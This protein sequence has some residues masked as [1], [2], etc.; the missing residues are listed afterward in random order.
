M[1]KL[2]QII[3]QEVNKE[4]SANG[5]YIA[6][7]IRFNNNMIEYTNNEIDI[8]FQEL[9]KEGYLIQAEKE[10]YYKVKEGI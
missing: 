8:A 10:F 2:K 5:I 1:S 4:G 9:I 3:L 6:F 7:R